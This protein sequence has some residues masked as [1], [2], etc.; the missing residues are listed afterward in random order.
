MHRKLTQ[1]I[2]WDVF[3]SDL[4]TI[5]ILIKRGVTYRKYARRYSRCVRV[6]YGKDANTCS[7][8][9]GNTAQSHVRG[10]GRSKCKVI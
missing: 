9:V 5:P 4:A 8:H 7:R 2:F 1:I 6:Q 10:Y 3:K